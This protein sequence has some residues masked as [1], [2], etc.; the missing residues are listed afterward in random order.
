MSGA[1]AASIAEGVSSATPD[2]GRPF[3]EIE[4]STLG[5]DVVASAAPRQRTEGAPE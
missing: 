2:D 1:V 3:G 4:S 5:D